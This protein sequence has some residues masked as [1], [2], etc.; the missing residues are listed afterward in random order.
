[1]IRG[2]IVFG[3]VKTDNAVCLEQRDRLR[4]DRV[5]WNVP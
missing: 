3:L 2:Q 4:R 1:M 5:E